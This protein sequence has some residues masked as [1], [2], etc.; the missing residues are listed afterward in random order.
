VVPVLVVVVVVVVVV[1]VVVVVVVV[2][3]QKVVL[4]VEVWVVRSRFREDFFVFFLFLG[5]TWEF[6]VYI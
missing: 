2:V 3:I 4:P 1:I 6:C 5:V